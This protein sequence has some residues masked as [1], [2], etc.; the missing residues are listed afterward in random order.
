MGD[1]VDDVGHCT[2]V[3]TYVFMVEVQVVRIGLVVMGTPASA[4]L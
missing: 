4:E 2:L 3:E 1:T